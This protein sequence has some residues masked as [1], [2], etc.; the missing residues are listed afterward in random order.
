MMTDNSLWAAGAPR[1]SELTQMAS[2]NVLKT[3]WE[4][5][6]SARCSLLWT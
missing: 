6:A 4:A 5:F 3:K 2:S 1:I